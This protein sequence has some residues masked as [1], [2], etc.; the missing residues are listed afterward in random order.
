MIQ[1]QLA[2]IE[3]E[4]AEVGP[5]ELE[6]ELVLEMAKSVR[7]SMRHGSS[8]LCGWCEAKEMRVL[9]LRTVQQFGM[10]MTSLYQAEN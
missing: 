5:M 3:Q 4:R 7:V 2:S 10:T 6:L 9:V 8:R 1:L